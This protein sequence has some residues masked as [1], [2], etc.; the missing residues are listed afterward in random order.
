M[1]LNKNLIFFLVATKRSDKYLQQED[2]F[3]NKKK[4]KKS[5]KGKKSKHK[6][7]ST[8]SDDDGKSR[9]F[10]YDLENIKVFPFQQNHIQCT[11]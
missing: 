6:T 7:V 4:T 8:D 5:K 11:L 2:Q 9:I 10:R 1:S 3:R